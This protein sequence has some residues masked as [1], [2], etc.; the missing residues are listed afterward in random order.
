MVNP[1]I[2]NVDNRTLAMGDNEHSQQILL[3]GQV[4]V[5]GQVLGKVTASG[6]LIKCI[7]AAVDGSEIPAYVAAQALSP[8]GADGT[9]TTIKKGDVDDSLL[10]FNAA[11][12]LL[13]VPAGQ[14]RNMGELLRVVG[15]CANT[16]P[17]VLIQDNQ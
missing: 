3:D 2:T 16:Y 5:K 12:G 1:I 15:I 13:T 8:S 17:N 9:I 14:D 6:K 4:V 7:A 11:E 10:V